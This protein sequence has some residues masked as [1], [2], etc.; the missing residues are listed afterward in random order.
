MCDSE[1]FSSDNI[2]MITLN[3]W[4]C[5]S[6]DRREA[7]RV[8]SG[9]IQISERLADKDQ[10]KDDRSGR[11][12]RHRDGY[13]KGDV[14]DRRRGDRDAEGRYSRDV[15]NGFSSRSDRDEGGFRSD[16]Y[17]RDDTRG[18]KLRMDREDPRYDNRL[19]DGS[20]RNKVLH[21]HELMIWQYTLYVWVKKIFS[22]CLECL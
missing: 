20:F 9:R 15:D 21:I 4:Y 5:C 17:D 16:R 10:R 12:D 18:S 13:E 7:A 3:W 22:N 6:R 2:E 1:W 8:G 19:K 11:Y 14:M